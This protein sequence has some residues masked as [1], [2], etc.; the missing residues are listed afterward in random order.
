MKKLTTISLFIFWAAVA[1]ILTAGLVFYQNNK[2]AAG[3]PTSSSQT[4]DLTS[5]ATIT[6]NMQ[7][8]AK[9]NSA[10]DCW[11]LI[12]NK[13]YN[14]TGYLGSHPGGAGAI[15]PACGHDATQD[16]ATKDIGR[17]HSS[18]AASLLTNYYIGDLNQTLAPQQVQQNVQ[19][20]NSL[21]PPPGGG[22]REYEDD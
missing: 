16:F 8:I 10:A 20:T 22:G 3:S 11:L 21:T 15:I 5:G 19:G 1:A 6:L 9:H 14:V 12:S 2:P 17:P 7:E 18:F 4:P 13:V